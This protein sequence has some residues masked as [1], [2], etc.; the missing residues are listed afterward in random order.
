M[1]SDV[2]KNAEN[3]Y[4]SVFENKGGSINF[5]PDKNGPVPTAETYHREVTEV[6]VQEVKDFCK[7]H[8]ITENDFL[9]FGVWPHSW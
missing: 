6:S 1:K 2:Y 9:Y 4:K 8:G 3:Y 5:Y 7:K